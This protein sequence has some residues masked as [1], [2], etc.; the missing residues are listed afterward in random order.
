VT[1]LPD[2]IICCAIL[3]NVLLGQ[4]HEQVEELIEVLWTK[5]LQGKVVDDS[6]V[7]L[8]APDTTADIAGDAVARDKRTDLGVHLTLQRRQ[9]L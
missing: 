7:P 9:Q 2:V 8:D 4:S 1:F 3:H 6:E 5:G